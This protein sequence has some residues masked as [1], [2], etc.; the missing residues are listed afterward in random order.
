MF[1]DIIEL[2]GEE[3]GSISMILVGVHGN[4]RCGIDAL[5]ELLPSLKIQRGRVFIAYGNPTAIEKNVRYIEANLNRLFKSDE[6]LSEKEKDSYEYSRAQFLKE[7]LDKA[8]YLLDIHASLTPNSRRF[9][10]CEENARDIAKQ[11]PISLRVSGFDNVEP[12]GTDYYMNQRGKVGVCIECGYFRDPSS[13]D[14]A[15]ENILAFLMACGNILGTP[16]VCTQS[17]IQ[18][19][20]L[21]L[22]KNNVVLGKQFKD[23]EKVRK[24]Q[25][26]GID[27]TE[28]VKMPIDGIILFARNRER[29][30]EEAFLYGQ[31][32]NKV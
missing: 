14:I 17:T 9:V 30:N 26:I 5:K 23:F 3:Q 21:Y 10:I 7:Y 25:I 1:E 11:L 12:G 19:E 8:D 6:M 28:E 32:K 29:P 22:T 16:K 13:K 31:Y 18:I 27:G 24:N 15:K 4:E 20:G 2:K